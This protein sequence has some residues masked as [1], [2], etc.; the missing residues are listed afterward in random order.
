MQRWAFLSV[1]V[2][3]M[4]ACGAESPGGAGGGAGGGFGGGGGGFGGGG[5][6][7]GATAC[8]PQNCTGCCFN[9]ACQPG[10]TVAGCGKSGASCAVC[11][12]N[13]ICRVDQTCGVDPE[14]TW[15]VQPTAAR[16]ASSNNGSTWDGDGSAPDPQ[17]LMNCGDVTPAAV[18]PEASDT[19]QPSWSSG[20]CTGKAKDL[21]RAGW[22][23]QLFDI[24]AFADDT[25]TASLRVTLTE[26][27]F[28]QGGFTLQPSGGMQSMTVTMRPQ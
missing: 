4:M 27:D 28:I 9:G 5:G 1:V 2:V 12:T 10:S 11:A 16:I 24:D 15:V 3:V 23:F 22:T 14:R 8:G 19:Y 17:V 6:G 25:I 13:Q 20:G 7:G 21:L 26:A 18:T